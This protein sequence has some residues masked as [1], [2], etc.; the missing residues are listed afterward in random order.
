MPLDRVKKHDKAFVEALRGSPGYEKHL[1][2]FFFIR[3]AQTQ[4]L[5]LVVNEL[6]GIFNLSISENQPITPKLSE[7]IAERMEEV[8]EKVDEIA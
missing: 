5:A 3:S 6:L 2:K 8:L 7:H 4:A 1:E